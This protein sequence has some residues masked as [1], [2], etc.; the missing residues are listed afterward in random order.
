MNLIGFSICMNRLQPSL[1]Y[2]SIKKFSCYFPKETG[3]SSSKGEFELT[4]LEL[5]RLYSIC[6]QF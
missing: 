5:A 6:F 1:F 2:V 4:E 3:L